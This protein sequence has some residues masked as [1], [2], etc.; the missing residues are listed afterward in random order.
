MKTQ[1]Q[2][3]IESNFN[4]KAKIRKGYLILAIISAITIF[5]AIG[6]TINLLIN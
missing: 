5:F 1:K 3:I 2:M 4:R 6:V